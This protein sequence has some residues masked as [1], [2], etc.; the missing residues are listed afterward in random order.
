M[1]SA[2]DELKAAIIKESVLA[3]P[4]FSK[5]FEVHT[6]DSDFA[7]GGILMQEGHPIAFESRKL[8]EAK[9]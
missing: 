4:D 8:N 6:D 9:R 5:A 3:L 1:S 2:F 7:I